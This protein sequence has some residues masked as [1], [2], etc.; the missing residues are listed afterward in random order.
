MSMQWTQDKLVMTP[1]AAAGDRM[2]NSLTLSIAVDFK[3]QF[4]G[5]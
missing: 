3:C 1:G 5:Q 2:I 4:I